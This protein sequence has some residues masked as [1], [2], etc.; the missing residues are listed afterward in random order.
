MSKRKKIIIWLIRSLLLFAILATATLALAPKLINL[1]TVRRNIENKISREVG[2]EIK[3]QHLELAYFPRPHAL[4][5]KAEISLPESI[6][7]KI[8]RLKI[9][10]KISS[11]LKGN[12]QIGVIE[13]EYADYFMKLPQI[14]DER[15]ELAEILSLFDVV[16]KRITRAV[17]A[18]PE[19]KLPD[20]NLGIKD[21]KVNLAGPFGHTIKLREVK[22]KYERSPNKLGFSIECKSNLWERIDIDVSWNPTDL[23][24]R[25][26]IK[27]SQFHPQ[28]L[29]A[30]LFPYSSLK[31]TDAKADLTIDLTSDGSGQIEAIVNGAIPR[32]EM[33]QGQEKLIIKG[34]SI[35]GSVNISGKSATVS[36]AE[37]KLDYP[38]LN[39]TGTLSYDENQPDIQLTMRGSRVE[40]DSTRQVA[41]AL[42]GES[43]A[44]R[45]IFNIIRGGTLP[46]ITLLAR[47]QTF[48]ELSML[49]NV[50]V[51]GQITEGRLFIPI[52]QLHL[53]DVVGDAIISK[54][55]FQ[56]ED[57]KG[58]MGNSSAQNGKITLGLTRIGTPFHFEMHFNADLIQLPPIL[59][60][61][62]KHKGFLNELALVKEFKGS[63]T[64]FLKL[65]E[66][67][68]NLTARVESSKVHVMARYG[69]VP[70]P[71]KID[72]RQFVY[73]GSHISFQN[74]NANIG[75][76]SLIRLSSSI[77]WE[78]TPSLK[79]KSKTSKIDTAELYSWLRS[80]DVLKK[81]LKNIESLKG[82]VSVE[83]MNIRGP[84]LSPKKWRFQGRGIVENLVLHSEKLPKPLQVGRG[85]FSWRGTQIDFNDVDA[86]M[87]RSSVVQISGDVNWKKT[88][89][90]TAKSGPALFYLEDVTPLI[91]SFKDFSH[92]LDQFQ[93]MNATLAF[94]HMALSCPISGT[95]YGQLSLS[96]DIKQLVIHS[97]RL[98]NPLRVSNGRFLLRGTQLAL[99]AI[100]ASLGK[101]T[102]SKLT[103]GFDWDEAASFGIHSESIELFADEIYPWLLSFEKIQPA[104]RD[105]SAIDGIIGV[106]DLNLKGPLHHPADWHYNLTCKMQ[107]LVL[108][109]GL[110][111]TPVTV[112]NGTFD[113][114]TETSGDVTQNRVN[115]VTTNLTWGENHLTLVGGITLSKKDAL[116]DM[117]MTADGLN[118]NQIKNILDYIEKRKADPDKDAWKGHLLGTLKI[119]SDTFNYKTYTVRP[120]QAEA[121]FKPGEVIITVDK[122]ILCDISLRG[123]VK[124]SE[125]TLD[126]FFVPSAMDQN[127]APTL[128]CITDEKALA[129]GR[130]NL[131]GEL[132]AK[133]KPEAF[134]RSLTG[135]VAFSAEKGRIHRLTLLAKILALLN[136]TEIYKGQLPDLTGA[137]FAYHSV[138]AN[139]TIR[140]EK[141]IIHES[142]IDG[143][144]MGIVCKGDIDLDDM[145]M[146]LIILVAPFKTVDRIVDLI[147]FVGQILG[148]KLI[149]IPFRAK[150]DLKNP[151]V[152]P[153]PATAVGSELLGIVERTLK[154]PLTIIQPLFPGDKNKKSVQEQSKIE[155]PG[156][157]FP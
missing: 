23:E 142:H 64:G 42:M 125:Q 17:G 5:H 100:N 13:L 90:F 139:A 131:N 124:V 39:L 130:Y 65:G 88:H 58:R 76:T 11:L 138:K 109:S 20:L 118:W 104:F 83:N 106:Y 33:S 31:V 9:F 32:L 50:I 60:R 140:G 25:G 82:S 136:I 18:L 14:S 112:N 34:G 123:Q 36:L 56:G 94:Q 41:L 48:A 10:P 102:I 103:A 107:D 93:P 144:S 51:Q 15:P 55:I 129:T 141:I 73:E 3:Y 96:G 81:N 95:T 62:V 91:F 47:G 153:L 101:S 79:V 84:L 28:A 69:R 85:R 44:I 12:L 19:Y 149:S 108:H 97:K 72:G 127:L 99:Q 89:L 29:L 63:A 78:K 132:M 121:S 133:T 147:P 16:L 116:L 52:V 155:N 119:Q 110:F 7:V 120:L 114:T 154:L 57:F 21:G 8:Q 61:I 66:D 145:T 70:Y 105:V 151:D 92:T 156:D 77:D 150:G 1:E 115:L 40:L 122:G 137:G 74:V 46:W 80:F 113:L 27:L 35:K 86:T 6:T 152:L 45:T 43:K 54:G 98:P 157:A 68:K 75:K 2:G 117:T 59:G 37:L 4:A 22:A 30:Y 24:G 49:E 135:K 53:Q 148:G 111:G 128:S 87:G 26:Q 143:A 71:I 126:I 67:F 38:K 146:N 134:R